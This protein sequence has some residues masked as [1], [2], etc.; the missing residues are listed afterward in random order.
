MFDA[1]SLLAKSLA[2]GYHSPQWEFDKDYTA[3]A[4]IEP[5]AARS[6][7]WKSNPQETLT[8]ETTFRLVLRRNRHA[9]GMTSC[10]SPRTR[11]VNAP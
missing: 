3:K 9:G 7:D 1:L 4:V 2:A 10:A 11:R 6:L 8:I 5:Q